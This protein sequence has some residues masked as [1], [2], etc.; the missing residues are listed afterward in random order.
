MS[1]FPPPPVSSAGT[2]PPLPPWRGRRLLVLALVVLVVLLI[3]AGFLGQRLLSGGP[4]GQVAPLPS[5]SG[6]YAQPPLSAQQIHDIAHLSEH[7]KYKALASLY[8]DH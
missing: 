2:R 3:I 6:P 5:G 4:G 1:L 7:M 8:V